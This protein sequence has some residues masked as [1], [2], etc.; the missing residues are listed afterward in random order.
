M[1]RRRE[2]TRAAVFQAMAGSEMSSE[3]SEAKKKKEKMTLER[4]RG[5]T[6]HTGHGWAGQGPPQHVDHALGYG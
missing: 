5:L 1:R 4:I 2:A 3:T 6:Q